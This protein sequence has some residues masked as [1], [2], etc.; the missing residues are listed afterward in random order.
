MSTWQS[1]KASQARPHQLHNRMAWARESCWHLTLQVS[2]F[3][4][5]ES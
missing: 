2:G 3:A 1:P 4:G 5:P